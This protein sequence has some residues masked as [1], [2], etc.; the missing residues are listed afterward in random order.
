VSSGRAYRVFPPNALHSI[1]H[2]GSAYDAAL[3]AHPSRY[4]YVTEAA[5]NLLASS[6][7][8]YNEVSGTADV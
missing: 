4:A 1:K 8:E 2:A 6:R 3:A 5:C 7:L